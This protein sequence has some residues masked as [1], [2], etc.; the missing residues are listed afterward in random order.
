MDAV[1]VI[2]C[3]LSLAP[4]L[5]RASWEGLMPLLEVQGRADSIMRPSALVMPLTSQ[6]AWS[7][8]PWTPRSPSALYSCTRGW[9]WAWCSRPLPFAPSSRTHLGSH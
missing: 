1:R 3:A 5:L 4:C 2:L 8:P 7:Q 6:A 9:L